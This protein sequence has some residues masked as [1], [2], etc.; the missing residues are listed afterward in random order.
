MN[1]HAGASVN[2]CSLRFPSAA[3][4]VLVR[5][6]RVACWSGICRRENSVSCGICATPTGQIT[7]V[8][9]TTI[10]SSVC[11][12]YLN[13][14]WLTNAWATAVPTTTITSSVCTIYLNSVW[15]TNAWTTAVPTT[16]I[17]SSVCTIYLNSVWLTNAWIT[18]VPTTTI[19]S[20]VC[21]IYLNSVW[22]TNA[23]ARIKEDAHVSSM[24][25]GS[26][27]GEVYRL[28]LHLVINHSVDIISRWLPTDGNHQ[29][30]ISTERLITRCSWRR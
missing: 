11:T 28:Q 7:A 19:A 18:A 21:T 25:G 26:T 17:T 8:P 29:L 9:T 24:P 5:T 2:C 23:W 12:I 3:P 20:S 10:A 6:S 13:S 14:V 1:I 15:L 27:V 30:M 22:L 4:V 16:T